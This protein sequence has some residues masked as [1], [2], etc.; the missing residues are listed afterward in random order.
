MLSKNAAFDSSK[1]RSKVASRQHTLT[2][3]HEVKHVFDQSVALLFVA[4]NTSS[5]VRETSIGSRIPVVVSQQSLARFE[6]FAIPTK[7]TTWNISELYF[8]IALGAHKGVVEIKE[9]TASIPAV[10][11]AFVLFE[12]HWMC[13]I[14]KSFYK[15]D[16]ILNGLVFRST[17]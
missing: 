1:K 17:I 10:V 8:H 11:S 9:L 15:V 14:S 6:V 7:S 4:S 16:D 2:Y 5:N 12:R 13:F 3:T